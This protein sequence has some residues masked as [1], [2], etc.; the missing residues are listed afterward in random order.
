MKRLSLLSLGL[1]L[2]GL[3]VSCENNPADRS[4]QDEIATL[5]RPTTPTTASCGVPS[6]KQ[7]QKHREASWTSDQCGFFLM[8]E[9]IEFG[10]TKTIF[11]TPQD[12]R[13]EDY[14]SGRFG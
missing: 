7:D 11:T 4:A 13:T 14:I 6:I 2:S 10:D 1:V 5:Q 12:K 9:F 3:I 8:G